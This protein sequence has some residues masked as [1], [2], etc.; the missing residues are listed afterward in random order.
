VR[1]STVVVSVPVASKTVSRR[2]ILRWNPSGLVVFVAA[3]QPVY[4]RSEDQSSSLTNWLGVR[5]VTL[6]V[7]SRTW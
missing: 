1:P 4:S 5:R 3:V 2:S 7:P 6:S